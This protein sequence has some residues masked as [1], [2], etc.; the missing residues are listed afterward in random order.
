[1]KLF[2]KIALLPFLLSLVGGCNENSEATGQGETGEENIKI[3]YTLQGTA[4]QLAP[5]GDT[6]Y[7]GLGDTMRV[8]VEIY[9]DLDVTVK[10]YLIE[11]EKTG[12]Y[13][14]L[15]IAKEAGWAFITAYSASSDLPDLTDEVHICKTSISYLL[16]VAAAPDFT[17][18]VGDEILRNK[19]ETDLEA[20]YTI[21]FYNFYTLT[22]NTATSGG[23]QLVTAQN[24]TL[25]GTFTSSDVFT[26]PDLAL[27]YDNLSYSFTLEQKDSDYY[28]LTQDLT[29]AFR[30]KYPSGN[31]NEVSIKTL[32]I[33]DKKQ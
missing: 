16:L 9:D 5:D 14:Y 3:Y 20:N 6:I 17:I 7:V 8:F 26:L 33:I 15:C 30:E 25:Y 23:L 2:R 32:S 22:C 28:Y 12:D 27:S 29:E 10:I 31:I 1:M 13:E 19:I 24:D 11:T 4:K 18:D 21:D